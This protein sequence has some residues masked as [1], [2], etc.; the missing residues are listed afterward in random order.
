MELEIYS[1]TLILQLALVYMQECQTSEEHTLPVCPQSLPLLLVPSGLEVFAS[2]HF[3]IPLANFMD[4]EIKD[5]VGPWN[6]MNKK[7]FTANVSTG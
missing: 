7:S 6:S 5:S 2:C 4:L 3:S 1:Y